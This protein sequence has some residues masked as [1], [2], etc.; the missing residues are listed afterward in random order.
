M[1]MT[2]ISGRGAVLT[3]AF[4][5]DQPWESGG[6]GT[7]FT[8][9]KPGVVVKRIDVEPPRP[10]AAIRDYTAHITVTR[11]RL[12]AILSEERKRA[13]PRRFIL[14]YITEILD[15]SLSTHWACDISDLH[16]VAVWLLQRRAAGVSLREYFDNLPSPLT[17][18]VSKRI[19][20]HVV[21]RM[22]TLRRADLV[23]L[24]C[25]H[26]NIFYDAARDKVTMIDL[27]G[28]GI[29][30][31]RGQATPMRSFSR[32]DDDWE[33][34]PLTLGHTSH[35][36]MPP[37]YPQPGVP[38]GPRQGN[39]LFAERWVLLDT[40]I[41]VL[42]GGRANVLSW[43]EDAARKDL[44]LAYR[45]ITRDLDRMRAIGTEGN[46]VVTLW[47]EA[48]QKTL[49]RLEALYRSGLQPFTERFCI[50]RGYPPSV[51]FF[52]ELAQTA[53][54]EPQALSGAPDGRPLYDVYLA[55]LD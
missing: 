11:D 28:C 31:R 51:A 9:D 54:F 4:A 48:W 39:Y 21:R 14:D 6:F 1:S 33:S 20:K 49:R 38:C 43:L 10:L 7:I 19:A 24:D 3:I 18:A 34:A 22:R 17:E 32:T 26:E 46:E 5:E 52:G 25:V 45:S 47:S 37:W 27:D 53:Y 55:H 12:D 23:H 35:V 40:I 41:R 2:A 44:G 15:Y 13:V 16:I 42:T 30:R 29:V 50:A 36:R 8:V